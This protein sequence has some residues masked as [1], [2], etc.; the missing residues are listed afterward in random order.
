ML[1]TAVAERN[2]YS[3]AL[4][5]F[6]IAANAMD[7]DNDIREMIKFPERVLTVSVPVRMEGGHIQALRSLSRA[8]QHGARSRQRWHTVSPQRVTR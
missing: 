1:A 4:E 3:L 7:L 5:N 2:A 6:E 8:A